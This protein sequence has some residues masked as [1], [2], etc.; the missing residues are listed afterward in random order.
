M[1]IFYSKN[2]LQKYIIMIIIA[3]CFSSYVGNS[4][5]IDYSCSDSPSGPITVEIEKCPLNF[6][7]TGGPN[8]NDGNTVQ[9]K[10]R[11]Q[12]F[13]HSG[14][15]RFSLVDVSD[16]PGYCI[17]APKFP[18]LIG[19]HSEGWKDLQFP[20]QTGFVISGEKNNIAESINDDLMEVTITVQSYDYGAYGNIL[21]ELITD[22]DEIILGNIES[23]PQDLDG[24]YI[25][26]IANQNSDVNGS[27]GI[28]DDLDDIPFGNGTNGD[29]ISRFEEYRGMLINAVHKRLDVAK[30][31]VFVFLHTSVKNYVHYNDNDAIGYF[32]SSNLEGA[33][34]HLVSS[35]E[36]S[37]NSFNDPNPFG[38]NG[39]ILA[40]QASRIINFNF[41]NN[42]SHL[43]FAY[44]LRVYLRANTNTMLT[45]GETFTLPP[46]TPKQA[47]KIH[48][49]F[50]AFEGYERLNN[51]IS[52]IDTDIQITNGNYSGEFNGVVWDFQ[53]EAAYRYLK[54]FGKIK[55]GNEVIRYQNIEGTTFKDCQRGFDGTTAAPHN[56]WDSKVS[57]FVDVKDV[58]HHNLA[59]ELGHGVG[60][61]HYEYSDKNIMVGTTNS[62][63]IIGFF[64]NG[65]QQHG[66][67]GG[68]A[69][70]GYF[71]EFVPSDGT[72]SLEEFQIKDSN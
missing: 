59:H 22:D 27:N 64:I 55:I 61:T 35:E 13:G 30:K 21:V 19:L 56:L 52:A 58:F 20:Q 40:H 18:P 38:S 9:I 15:F 32:T 63:Q 34:V 53:T 48:I 51:N 44:V 33:N 47:T 23:I 65:I 62:N 31:D 29:N 71:N 3:I 25:A 69:G 41:E 66:L 70:Y 46:Y 37:Y 1:L 2:E 45:L 72:S 36:Y 4:Q 50:N 12:G 8:I 11:V 57:N 26:D 67:Y 43:D 54:P 17:N 16:I 24:N 42:E 5:N 49:Y 39:D 10:A 6:I 7:P 68:Y 60:I 28:G 14:K